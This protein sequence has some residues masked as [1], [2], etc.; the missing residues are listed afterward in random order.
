MEKSVAPLIVILAALLG[1][2]FGFYL[3][4]DPYFHGKAS[5][6]GVV[7]FFIEAS[8]DTTAPNILLLSPSD[9]FSSSSSSITFQFNAS[10]N[11]QSISNCSLIVDDQ[12]SATSTSITS[13][14]I[15][16]FG[17]TFEDGAHTWSVNCTDGSGNQGNSSARTFTIEAAAVPEEGG[18]AGGY[19]VYLISEGEL[20]EGTSQWMTKKSRLGFIFE[21]QKYYATLEAISQNEVTISVRPALPQEGYSTQTIS[22]KLGE[23]GVIDLNGDGIPELEFAFLNYLDQRAE[24]WIKLAQVVEGE[25]PAPSPEKIPEWAKIAAIAAGA[26]AIAWAIAYSWY[27]Y[28]R[29]LARRSSRQIAGRIARMSGRK[30]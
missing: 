3:V 27:L 17:G 15:S 22:L 6:E 19:A 26:A 25:A 21:G 28:Q 16:E 1:A 24:I 11:S 18:N 29:Y 30:R 14:A 7:S 13:S 12:I 10:D 20:E 23:N 5:D 8:A 9:G 4:G 2:I